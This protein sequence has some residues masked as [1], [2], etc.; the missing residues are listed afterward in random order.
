[1][2]YLDPRADLTF[3]KVFGEHPDL[4][5]SFLNAMLPLKDDELVESIEYLTPEMI[6]PTP[7]NKYSIVDVRCKDR[8]DRCF[9]VEMQMVWSAEFQQRVLLNASKAYVN[10]SAKGENYELLQPVYSLNLVNDTFEKDLPAD[11]FY[12][13]YRL[14][15]Y[16][17]SNKVLEGFHLV[18]IEL[19]KFKP[20]NAMEK[21]MQ[22][23]W[24]RFLTETQG[25]E[26]MDETLLQDPHIGKALKIVEESSYSEDE[27]YFYDRYWDSISCE[28]TLVNDGFRKG[29]AQGLEQG[30][31]QGLQQG[32]EQGLQ[33]G[34]QKGL[35]KGF[36]Q[37]RTEGEAIGIEKGRQQ[38]KLQMARALKDT[39]IP[40][41]I[42]L[43]I[44]GLSA[45]E[46]EGL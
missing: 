15:H 7:T 28:V 25:N 32:L 11:E 5:I 29:E 12:H 21:K 39:D 8:K 45:T 46:I 38:E 24:L 35:Q 44:T 10:Q 22:Q 42:I 26:E 4:M 43:K 31:Q 6:P 34:L 13:Y 30:L 9:I 19:P 1:M 20:Q 41:E 18:F 36:E 17:H 33:Q 2:K 3:K 16:R 40:T 23:L 27:L 37:G 14:V